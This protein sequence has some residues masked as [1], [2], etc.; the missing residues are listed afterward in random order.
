MLRI[1]YADRPVRWGLDANDCICDPPTPASAS[2][3]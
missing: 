1:G 2:L 3:D